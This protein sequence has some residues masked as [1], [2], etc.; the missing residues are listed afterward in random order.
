MKIPENERTKH[1]WDLEEN[2]G[3]I[4]YKNYKVRKDIRNTQEALYY[5]YF[6]DGYI[7]KLIEQCKKEK[8]PSDETKIL[9]ITPYKLQEIPKND[10]FEGLNKPKK[11]C[12]KNKRCKLKSV[13]DNKYLA[14]ER[15]IMLQIRKENGELI[16][17]SKIKELILHE[18][19]HTM[20]NHIVYRDKGNHGKDFKKCEKFLIKISKK[21]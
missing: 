8:E 21:I 16:E 18:L 4:K 2:K 13:M 20:C 9:I 3:F 15:L 12:L 1:L 14:K 7:Q 5:L 17:W 6:I 11:I 19:C 10:I